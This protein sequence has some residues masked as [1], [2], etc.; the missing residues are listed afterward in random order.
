MQDPKEI[1]LDWVYRLKKRILLGV[2]A[3]L[4]LSISITLVFIAVM[5]RNNLIE[6]GS[7]KTQELSNAVHSALR[8]LMLTRNPGMIQ[9]T[10]ENLGKSNHSLT[11]AFI[12][13]KTGRVAYSSDR[14]DLGKILDKYTESSCRGC[15]QRIDSAPSESTIFIKT[16]DA[17]V[18]RSVRVIYN[19]E[20]CHGCHSVSDRINGKLIIDRSLK[21]TYSLIAAIELIIFGSG[22]ACLVFLAPLLSRIV[23]KGFTRY[24]EEIF[25]Q[26]I[27][28]RL[29][30]VM[31]ERLSKTIDMEELKAIVFEII[32]ESLAADEID[33]VVMKDRDEYKITSWSRSRDA[34][35]RKKISGEDPLAGLIRS[36]IKGEIDEERIS[37]DGRMISLPIKKGSSSFALIAVR[38]LDGNFDTVRPG[39]L[40]IMS[41]HISVAFENALLYQIAIT[42]E[43][44]GLYT[45]RHF[46][47]SI[48]KRM[49]DY[50]KFGEKFAML[51]ADIDDFK[52]VNDSHGHMVGDSVLRD[53]A[54]R[55]LLSVRDN[56][57]AFRYGGE[58]F[59]VV[60]PSTDTR[61]ARHVAERIRENIACHPFEE[62]ALNLRITVSIGVSACPDNARTVKELMI[63]ADEALY[64]AKQTGK[65]RVITSEA[66]SN[67]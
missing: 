65:N 16:E 55:I 66:V 61:G 23:G 43:L 24:I 63:T 2:T 34:I 31:I 47:T 54:R 5:L 44:T 39:L 33:M 32:K 6:D 13:D 9:N 64:R 29:L 48:G 35:F 41:N 46:N 50:E 51:I 10:V 19:E 53:V 59:V 20:S 3:F 14:D 17:T 57:L 22:L 11:K 12:L 67:K 37:E 26:N 25:H 21:G 18:H 38:K 30:Y 45:H 52:K 49:E 7:I 40:K 27:E 15:H 42:D 36:W 4:A 62:G 58:E 8:S 60:L 28:L 1:Q 56:D